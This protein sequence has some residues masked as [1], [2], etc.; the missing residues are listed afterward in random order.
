[1]P[2]GGE[3]DL[4][5]GAFNLRAGL[6]YDHEDFLGNH[7]F[8]PR[9]SLSYDLPFGL[10]LTAGGN[11]YYG[12]SF[13]GYAL[14]EQYGVSRIY[15]RT[16]TISNGQYIWSD[17]WALSTHTESTRYSNIGLDTPYTDELTLALRG[18]V[19][20]IGGEFRV[21]GVLRK[22]KNQFAA[23]LAETEE[24]IK[25][26]GQTAT[27]RVYTI[28]NDG[29]RDYKGLTVEYNRQLGQNHRLTLSTALSK[30]E[31]SNISYFDPAEET[32]WGD[33]LVYYK[34]EVM[35]L[36]QAIS[37]N[38]VENYANPLVINA[39]I[40]SR[41]LDGRITTNINARWRDGFKRV[42]DSGVNTDLIDGVRY[43]IYD[44]VRYKSAVE[45]N[46]GINAEVVKTRYGSATVEVR[47]N[48]I[49][50]TATNR[51]YASTTNPW[52]LGRNFWLTLRLKH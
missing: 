4:T 29:T 34:G 23:S 52:Q 20:G 15:T 32:E 10:T 42:E 37:D 44:V 38:Q 30:T 51:D 7:V 24:F 27:R 13:L 36:L 16:P 33:A 31:A 48:N 35:S 39:D 46:L 41:W 40:S 17:S 1:M 22:S 26:T 18:D 19:P 3:Y 8:S 11:R 47:A 49:F 45:V 5:L 14:R 21:R 28:T 6:R 43:D 12:R 9:L 2:S 25:D 50:N